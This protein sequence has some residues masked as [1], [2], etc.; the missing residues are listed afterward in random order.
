MNPLSVVYFVLWF[1]HGLNVFFKD[2]CYGSLV[3]SV[4]T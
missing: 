4:M 2:S 3:L 1:R